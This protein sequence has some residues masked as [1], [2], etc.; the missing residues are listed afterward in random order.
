MSKQNS[1][2]LENGFEDKNEISG[3]AIS[4]NK[5][6]VFKS[7]FPLTIGMVVGV[8]GGVALSYIDDNAKVSAPSLPLV[9]TDNTVNSVDTSKIKKLRSEFSIGNRQE[10]ISTLPVT[11]SVP[12]TLSHTL[13][14][15]SISGIKK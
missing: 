3:D 11:M 10:K 15:S 9:N 1:D 12:D 4:S 13:S 5:I 8:L 6:Q 2:L 14:K 7:M